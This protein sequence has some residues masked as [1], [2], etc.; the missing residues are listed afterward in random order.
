MNFISFGFSCA[1]RVQVERPTCLLRLFLEFA[2]TTRK[3]Y[4][5]MR[6]KCFKKYKKR[7][8][9]TLTG[10]YLTNYTFHLQLIRNCLLGASSQAFRQSLFPLDHEKPQTRHDVWK[11]VGCRREKKIFLTIV[12]RTTGIYQALALPS[13]ILTIVYIL[14][15]KLNSNPMKYMW[16][17]PSSYKCHMKAREVKWLSQGYTVRYKIGIW[18]QTIWLQRYSLATLVCRVHILN[19]WLKKQLLYV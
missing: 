10:I 15:Y 16:L 12:A 7:Q 14:L 11:Q 5:E 8:F 4:T 13:I 6:K 2:W 3:G 9:W 17:F 18:S 1:F 19:K